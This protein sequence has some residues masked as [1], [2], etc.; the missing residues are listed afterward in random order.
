MADFTKMTL[1]VMGWEIVNHLPE[2]EGTPRKLT[3]AMQPQFLEKSPI[4]SM[5][6]VSRLAGAH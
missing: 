3:T 2:G 6:L 5:Q 1:A 4:S